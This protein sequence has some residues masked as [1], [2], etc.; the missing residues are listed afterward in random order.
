MPY[1]LANYVDMR[2][3]YAYSVLMTTTQTI[4]CSRCGRTLTSPAS[5]ARGRGPR[6]HAKV[7]AA[8]QAAD[9]TTFTNAADA[10]RKASELIDDNAIIPTRIAGQYLATSSDGLNT[11]LVD[12]VEGSCTCKGAQRAGRCYHL[13]TAVIL[14]AA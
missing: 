8:A 5:I 11:Y 3:E 7:R 10:Q 6:C 9:F 13:S 1:E 12:T 4:T 14:T 2:T